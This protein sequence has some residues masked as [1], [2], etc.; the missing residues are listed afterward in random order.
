MSAVK[1]E[2]LVCIGDRIVYVFDSTLNFIRYQYASKYFNQYLAVSLDTQGNTYCADMSN[3]CIQVFDRKGVYLHCFDSIASGAIILCQP[4]SVCVLDK[5]V[6]I[7]NSGDIHSLLV[8]ITDGYIYVQIIFHTH[9]WVLMQ[10]DI[11]M[12]HI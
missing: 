9:S 7:T 10:M 11:F 2:L 4:K 12:E 6:Y 8:F 3:S 5:Y 1:N